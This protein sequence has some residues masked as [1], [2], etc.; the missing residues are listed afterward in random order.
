[1]PPLIEA[2]S[3]SSESADH[4]SVYPVTSKGKSSASEE[5]QQE[6]QN[7][8]RRSSEPDCRNAGFG[9]CIYRIETGIADSQRQGTR[10]NF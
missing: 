8:Q 5:I 3:I 4:P 9:A 7:W 1:M 2:L 10:M 6:W